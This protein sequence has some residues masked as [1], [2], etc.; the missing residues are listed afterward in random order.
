MQDTDIDETELNDLE[1]DA[2]TVLP[3]KATPARPASGRSPKKP[4]EKDEVEE[5]AEN[6]QQSALVTKAFPPVCFFF[7]Y[8]F[9]MTWNT[10]I[11]GTKEIVYIDFQSVNLPPNFLR[12]AKEQ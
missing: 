5:L 3:K 8:R 10:A 2:A 7:S 9:P 4:K 11:D 1:E 6:L 12:M